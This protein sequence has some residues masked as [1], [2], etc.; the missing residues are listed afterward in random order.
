MDV[1]DV[2][3]RNPVYNVFDDKYSFSND[4]L[5]TVSY[6]FR[7]ED[8]GIVT[9][10]I[11]K[12][13]HTLGRLLRHSLLCDET[14]K[15]AGYRMDNPVNGTFIDLTM[16]FKDPAAARAQGKAVLLRHLQLVRAQVDSLE[17]QFR[18][19]LNLP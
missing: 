12:Q 1:M 2:I 16:H 11:E 7:D 6:R 14:I 10:R 17:K 19:Q 18:D 3:E 9:F 13:N 5:Q 15:W 8:K 4:T